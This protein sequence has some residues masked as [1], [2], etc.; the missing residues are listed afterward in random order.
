MN[1][2]LK[3]FAML[4]GGSFTGE[5][6]AYS[7]VGT[8]TRALRAGE[9]YLALRGPRFD[10][11]DFVAA[12]AAA[13]AVAA[14]VDRPVAGAAL[15]LISVADGQAALTAAA[16]GWRDRFGGVVVGVAGSNGKTTVKEMTA[17]ILAQR[18]ACLA[19]R[20]NLNNHIG[21][22]LTLL[23]LSDE[24]RSA[25]IEIGA[26]RP[27]EVAALV[28]IARPDVGLITNA[29][30]EHLEGFGDLD[31]VARAEGEMVAGLGPDDVA[32]INAD[33]TYADLWRGMTRARV[34]TFGVD[35][36]ADFGAADVRS[37]LTD[38]GFRTTFTLRAPQGERVVRL[39]VGGVHN[40][41]NAL[42][43]AA[44]AVAAGATLDDVV[45]GLAAMQP[46]AGRLQP[47]RTSQGARLIDD[48]YNANPS[49]MRAGID[50][51][52]AMPGK[53]WLVMGDMGELGE[54]ARASHIEIGRYARQRGVQ[55][56]F[57]TGPLSTLAVESF[58]AGAEWF[59]DTEALSRAVSAALSPDVTL[60]VKGSRSNRLER[61]VASLGGGAKEMH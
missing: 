24:H 37:E 3:D 41:R 60:L 52:V 53:P 16:R 9:I 19:T 7:G 25:V 59:A 57:A 6:R 38:R 31:G 20:G 51:L 28:R 26:N 15:P 32:I 14:V 56:L 48:S 61:V 50:V 12:A 34:V 40:L 21:V 13:G 11:N 2:T 45:A 42:A 47:G 23:R 33:D 1:R 44:A 4:C 39:N 30:A 46:V 36:P 10:G 29:G 22:P 5:D 54:H 49:S 43:A 18:G 8:D 17:A 35:R 27:G 58:G 55:R